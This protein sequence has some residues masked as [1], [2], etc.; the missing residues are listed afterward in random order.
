MLEASNSEREGE[1]VM[2]S[3][4]EKVQ[5]V[6]HNHQRGELIALYKPVPLIVPSKAI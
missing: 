3:L 4:S 1:R 6:L 5:L 2:G